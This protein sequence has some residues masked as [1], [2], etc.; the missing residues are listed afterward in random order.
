ML[1]EFFTTNVVDSK[2]KRLNL[3]YKQFPMYYVW[4]SHIRTWTRR[5]KVK[6]IGR[7]CTVNPTEGECYYLRLLLNNVH[8][9]T[10]YDLLLF[11]GVQSETFQKAA[12]LTGLLQQDGDIDKTMEEA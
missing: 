10:S 6:V 8:A 1:I 9:P 2:A 11:D 4:D 3:L 5:K 7:L 12:Y